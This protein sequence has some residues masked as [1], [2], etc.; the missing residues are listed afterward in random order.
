[1]NNIDHRNKLI[2][3]ARDK[4][5]TQPIKNNFIFKRMNTDEFWDIY[6]K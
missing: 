2:Q 6:S 1:M 4:S 5:F 3:N